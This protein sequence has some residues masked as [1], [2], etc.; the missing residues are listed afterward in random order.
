[1]KRPHGYTLLELAI[2]LILLALL[3]GALFKW[4]A[5]D[6]GQAQTPAAISK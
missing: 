5:A 6:G 3:F 4:Q 2:V 1:M